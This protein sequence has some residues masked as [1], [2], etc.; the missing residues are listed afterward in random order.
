MDRER[1]RREGPRQQRSTRPSPMPEEAR[2]VPA[3]RR[4]DPILWV[5]AI[6]AARRAE[7]LLG[8]GDVSP[9]QRSGCSHSWRTSFASATRSRPPRRTAASSSGWPRSTTTSACTA[10]SAKADAEY[11]AAFRAYGVDLDSLDPLGRQA[12]RRQPGRP[13]N[14]R[15][16]STSGGS[17]AAGRVLHDPAGADRLVAVAKAADPD[18]W[19]NRLRDTLGRME[20]GPA[21]GSKSLER[22][23]ATADVD[24]LPVTSVTRLA[25][26]LAFFGG[27]TAI[28]LL[29]RA[30]A[31]HRDDFWV[32]ADLGRELMASDRPERGGPVLRR[33]S[34]RPAQERPGPGRP[35]P[36]DPAE[37][38]ARRGCRCVS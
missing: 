27:R 30:Q 31:S 15:A 35:G 14:W 38:P 36:G 16:P 9:E 26:S 7:T 4:G 10:T 21:R 24:Q 8:G 25:A 13:P 11:A 2:A 32:N 5:E 34:G 28:A 12:A 6:E 18:P 29:R 1:R 23:A 3:P 33:R 19:R 22:L 20:G 17:C 37:R